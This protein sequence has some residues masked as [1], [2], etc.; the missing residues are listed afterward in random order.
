MN[1]V[2]I[3]QGTSSTRALTLSA[4]GTLSVTHTERHAQR[5]PREGWVEHD[6]AELLSNIRR[7]LDACTNIHSVGIDNQGESCM[8][9]LADTREPITPVVVWQDKRSLALLERMRRSGMEP[10][11]QEKAGLPLD[12]YFSA[13]KLAWIMQ[14]VP[15][16]RRARQS[17]RLRLGTTDAWFLDCLTGHFVTDPSTA[18][19]TSLM[20]LQSG[21]WDS[22]L[23]ELFGVPIDCLPEIVTSTGDFGSIRS[24]RQ[25]LP[26]TA[27]IVDQQ[28]ALYG[29]GCREA[30][31]TKMTFGTGAFA[32]MTTGSRIHHQP[33]K[34]LL[35]TVAWQKFG[36]PP[37]HAL[38][39]GIHTASA[40]L[41]WARSLGLFDSFD[42]IMH[43][44][45]KAAIDTGLAF[46]PALSGLACPHWQPEARGQWLGLSLEHRPEQLVQ[47]LLE[48][49]ALRAAEVLEA[50]SECASRRGPLLIDGGMSR[51]PY[52]VQFLSDVLQAPVQCACQPE[53]TGLGT[54][55][56]AAEG[57]GQNPEYQRRFQTWQPENDRSAARRQFRRAVQMSQDWALRRND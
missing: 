16:A 20:N 26:V 17:G 55:L 32:L 1:I 53:L 49:V 31:D 27:S 3:D 33:D 40:A 37:V 35:P 5:Y 13:G 30:G 48:G 39:G 21:Q 19:R 9:W 2:A 24:N 22:E 50:M 42:D 57:A 4:D 8:A 11:V 23:C 36:E 54:A 29:F 6:P 46:V 7:C 12:P 51:N 45:G 41:D 10:L 15:A 14:E 38:D 18:S 44:E 34:G 25:N 52:F 28:A 56:L 43:F 47:S